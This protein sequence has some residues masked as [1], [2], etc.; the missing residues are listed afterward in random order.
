MCHYESTY[1]HSD[2]WNYRFVVRD[3]VQGACVALKQTL[4][5]HN[6]LNNWLTWVI[7]ISVIV[8]ISVQMVYL[9]KA[10][11][12]FNTSVVTPI[13]YVVFTSCVILASAILFKEWGHLRPEDIVGNL[14]GFFTIISGIFL[15]QAFKDMNISLNNLPR[16]RKDIDVTRPAPKMNGMNG[17]SDRDSYSYSALLNNVE[18]PVENPYVTDNKSRNNRDYLYHHRTSSLS[19][20]MLQLSNCYLLYLSK[21]LY[22][23][24]NLFCFSYWIIDNEIMKQWK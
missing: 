17:I 21:Y 15:L 12:V 11:D 2:Y 1:V 3:G 24:F 13:L 10:L 8:C 7:L 23:L 6:E 14:C 9:N 18:T 16:A 4:A 20:I 5:G 22:I 19:W